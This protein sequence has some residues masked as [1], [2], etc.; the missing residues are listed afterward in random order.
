MQHQQV[1]QMTQTC[2]QH[3]SQTIAINSGKNASI[4]WCCGVSITISLLR[5][6]T[7]GIPAAKASLPFKDCCK[8]A[9]KAAAAHMHGL[10]SAWVYWP[11]CAA[12]ACYSYP[13]AD[14]PSTVHHEAVGFVLSDVATCSYVFGELDKASPC[15]LGLSPCCT[16]KKSEHW[17]AS[18]SVPDLPAE[19]AHSMMPCTCKYCLRVPNSK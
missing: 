8:W 3:C 1:T 2:H 9:A 7:S 10:L 18:E 15:V 6:S 13:S 17:L 19:Q 5:S 4:T 14:V 16:L 12:A 11:A